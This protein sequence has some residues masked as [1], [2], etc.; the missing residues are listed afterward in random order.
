MKKTFVILTLVLFLLAFVGCAAQQDSAEQTGSAS[1]LSAPSSS[2]EVPLENTA[3][4]SGM[5]CSDPTCTDA[6]HHHDCPEDCTDYDHHHNCP[7]DCTEAGHHHSTSS[8]T[9][10]A[11][12]T[13][14]THHAESHASHHGDSHH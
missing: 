2:T 6:S 12:Q 7:L 5:G 1:Q 9:A 14:G 10:G 11:A 8:S 13:A 3:F 4:I